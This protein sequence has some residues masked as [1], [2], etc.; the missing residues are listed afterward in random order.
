MIMIFKYSKR[1]ISRS[2]CHIQDHF[3]RWVGISVQVCWRQMAE[4]MN[5]LVFPVAVDAKRHGIVHEI[6]LVGDGMENL[7]N[8]GLLIFGEDV[9]EAKVVVRDFGLG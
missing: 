1:N 8:Q 9:L 2:S 5:E 7:I 4:L 6:V 3:G